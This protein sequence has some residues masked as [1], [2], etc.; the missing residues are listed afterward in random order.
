M[1]EFCLTALRI[2]EQCSPNI[3]KILSDEFYFFSDRCI[4][5]GNNLILNP[6]Y[7]EANNIYGQGIN[8]H[9]IV[10]MNGSG[11][12]SLLEIIY[13]IVNN[14]AC[15]YKLWN[16]KVG[17][18][19]VDNLVASL[20]FVIDNQLYE[21]QCQKRNAIL[22]KEG[23]EINPENLI[24]TDNEIIDMFYSII[25][26]YSMQSL[27]ISDFKDETTID[28]MKK[29]S[30]RGK[31]WLQK[32]FHKNDGYLTPLVLNPFRDASGVIDVMREEHLADQRLSLLFLYYHDK[33]LIENYQLKTIRYRF[34]RQ[35]VEKKM[36]EWLSWNYDENIAKT[37]TQNNDNFFKE[38][39]EAFGIDNINQGN[40]FKEYS[41]SYACFILKKKGVKTFQSKSNYFVYACIYLVC[42]I[43]DIA[44]TYPSY[45]DFS[46]IGGSA[47]FGKNVKN[48]K[49]VNDLIEKID[50]DKSHIT[51][52]VKRVEHFIKI[53]KRKG[54]KEYDPF[55]IDQY[56][57]TKQL[58]KMSFQELNESLP[59]SFFTPEI[60]LYHDD[61]PQKKDISLQKMSSGE[62]QFL[63]TISTF[64]YHLNNLQSIQDNN[65]IKYKNVNLILDEVEICFHPEYQRQFID[66]F[67]SLLNSLKLNDYFCF[68]I[69]FAT[70]SPFVLSDIPQNN[71]LYLENGISVNERIKVNPF[72]ANVNDVLAQSFFMDE[73]F[74]G[75]F[76]QRVVNSLALYLKGEKSNDTI[77][78]NEKKAEYF[79]KNTIGEPIVKKCLEALLKGYKLKE[80][81]K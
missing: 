4:R 36:S 31:P 35:H 37:T 65:R 79:I 52:K 12:S 27:I 44:G 17:L 34:N 61:D 81:F 69:L 51:A 60:I 24:K 43:L 33:M 64:I 30:Q 59:P 49:L 42:K 38:L 73:G 19:F 66:R 46:E 56:L 28:I 6:N 15:K 45:S 77:E 57:S 7:S 78:W 21:I 20:Y 39:Y 3:K 5:K 53:Y 32:I 23:K 76:A 74:V 10:G 80:D 1:K 18:Y 55:T 62:R 72:A 54:I 13:R 14:F 9:A 63:Y 70:H 71:I 67:I 41:N 47:N 29:G 48:P 58:K 8:L 75:K 25:T 16:E 22:L 11:K 2:D 50:D 40:F 68:N 26:N